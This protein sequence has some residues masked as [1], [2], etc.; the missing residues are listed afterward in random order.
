MLTD[1]FKVIKHGL[2]HCIS[3]HVAACPDAE[4]V[5][6]LVIVPNNEDDED[7]AFEVKLK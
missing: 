7:L 1:Q 6:E 3:E 4:D 5:R 2:V